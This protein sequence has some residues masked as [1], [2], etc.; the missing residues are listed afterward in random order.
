MNRGSNDEGVRGDM[1]S[2]LKE[3]VPPTSD[4]SIA[5]LYSSYFILS[6]DF[7]TSQPASFIDGN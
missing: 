3:S 7:M 2:G 6:H 4:T 5:V 1:M